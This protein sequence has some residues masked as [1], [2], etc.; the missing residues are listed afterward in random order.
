MHLL[1]KSGNIRVAKG[2]LKTKG[3]TKKG[4][5]CPRRMV[6]F[7]QIGSY[8]DT[9]SVPLVVFG[10]QVTTFVRVPDC[11][12]HQQQSLDIICP[13][14]FS[15]TH[16]ASANTVWRDSRRRRSR[17]NLSQRQQGQRE[18]RSRREDLPNN[19]SPVPE[20]TEEETVHSMCQ[21]QKQGTDLRE[22]NAHTRPVLHLLGV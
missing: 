1:C 6:R 21:S 7:P 8:T 22:N 5:K 12:Q 10:G 13:F 15:C 20:R 9:R 17:Y 14:S 4:S 16:T 3:T 11:R 2:L 18:I 19:R